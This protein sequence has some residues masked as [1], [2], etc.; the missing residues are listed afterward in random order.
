MEQSGYL[1]VGDGHEIFYDVVGNQDA[2]P[3]VFVHG[4]PG[5]GFSEKHKDLF[6]LERQ[7]VVL[8]DQRGAGR[9]KPYLE[10]AGNTTQKL[11]EDIEKLR[12]HFGLERILLAGA[13]WG[14]TLA[15]LYACTYPKYTHGMVLASIFLGNRKEARRF[16]DGSTKASHPTVWEQFVA[17]VPESERHNVLGFYLN[18]LQNGAEDEKEKYARTWAQ[19]DL[20]LSSGEESL[21]VANKSVGTVSYRSLALLTA[22]YI[23]NDFFIEEDHILKHADALAGIPLSIVQ[24]SEDAVTP[25]DAAHALHQAIDGSKLALI[26]GP[27]AGPTLIATL[28]E[29]V[30]RLS[31]S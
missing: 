19:Y 5:S 29:E 20:A 17:V 9:S 30:S 8:Y 3:I 31:R 11:V 25:P 28:K 1:D 22:Y 26:E 18:K 10:L 13:S 14:A 2:V 24:A 12:R 23:K 27:H 7:Q 6:D 16:I 21:E 4:G 15:L